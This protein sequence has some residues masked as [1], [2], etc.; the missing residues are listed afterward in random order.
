MLQIKIHDTEIL[1]LWNAD[2]K[3][4]K[5]KTKNAKTLTVQLKKREKN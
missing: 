3:S 2:A 1:H 4:R 5:T